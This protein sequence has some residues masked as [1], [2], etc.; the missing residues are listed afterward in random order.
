MGNRKGKKKADKKSKKEKQ[1]EKEKEEKNK[2]YSDELFG[3]HKLFINSEIDQ[4]A[5]C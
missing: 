4:P 5:V 2:K 1:K 3:E